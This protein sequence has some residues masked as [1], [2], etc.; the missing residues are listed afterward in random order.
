MKEKLIIKDLKKSYV[1][2]K[3]D[4]SFD[5]YE[6]EPL[7]L[8]GPSGSGKTTT[9]HMIAGFVAPD[10]GSIIKDGIDITNLPPEKRNIGIVF[11]DYALFPYLN[12]FSNI[13][14]GLKVKGMPNS[15]I[16][17]QVENIAK[18]LE[19]E[20]LLKKYPDNLSGG[21]K[22]RV[23]LA[24]AMIVKPDILLMDEPLSS[25]DAKI[26]ERLREDLKSFHKRFGITIIYVTHDQT[27]AMYLSE[28]IVVLSHGEIEQIGNAIDVYYH[29]RTEFVRDFVGKI[30]HIRFQ[31]NDIFIRPEDIDISRTHGDIKGRVKGIFYLG[32]ISEV[33]VETESD[34]ITVVKLTREIFNLKEGEDVYL[35]LGIEEKKN[36]KYGG[37]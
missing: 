19:I 34:A 10:S 1:D 27:E 4:L 30:N 11:Q 35:N 20:K 36:F 29:P 12:V 23:A 18:A 13:A 9:L 15:E 7:S 32:G 2:F 22:Q 24:R 3:V 8:L 33:R 26:R 14:F 31:G 5:V 21:E 16:K 37:D 6:G 17:E 25:L 28:R